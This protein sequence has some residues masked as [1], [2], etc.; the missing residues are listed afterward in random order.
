MVGLLLVSLSLGLSNLAAAIGIGLSGVDA[1][2]RLKTG[3]AFGFFE[4]LM[5]ILGLLIGQASS[6]PLGRIGHYIGATVLILCGSYVIWT[7]LAKGATERA[8][9]ERPAIGLRY[10]IVTGFA[11]SMD[12][13]VVGFALSFYHAPLPLAAGVIA[14]VSVSMT[15][16]GLEL[17]DRLGT[18]F[19]RWS[20]ELGG[21]V[22]IL[23]GLALGLGLF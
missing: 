10:L 17:G 20:E 1:R 9:L 2:T 19:E 4:G 15:L 18:R 3:L 8:E 14:V 11:L 21:A 23:V 12:N 22:L 5:P 13:L 7:G 6:G 16:V